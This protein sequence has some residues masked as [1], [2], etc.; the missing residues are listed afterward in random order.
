MA[1]V[2]NTAASP[3]TTSTP[4]S[5]TP[6]FPASRS[7]KKDRMVVSVD[8]LAGNRGVRDLGVLVVVGLAAVFLTSAILL[9]MAWAAG[10]RVTGRAPAEQ[11]GPQ[12]L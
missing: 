12:D 10:W 9:P 1:L 3:T 6:R 4:R 2:R 5:R 8:T 7:D 11:K